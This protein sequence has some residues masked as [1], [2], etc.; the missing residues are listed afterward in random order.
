MRIFAISKRKLKSQKMDEFK[1]ITDY[2][3]KTIEQTNEI[4]IKTEK[5]FVTEGMGLLFNTHISFTGTTAADCITGGTTWRTAQN[6]AVS[7][8]EVDVLDAEAKLILYHALLKGIAVQAN[9]THPGNEL[10]LVSTGLTMAKVGEE[11]GE[12]DK[13]VIKSVV[14]VEGVAEHADI[15]FNTSKK[16]CYGTHVEVKNVATGAVVYKHSK[17]KH[18]VRIDGCL[19]AI[20][21]MVRVAYDG[22]DETRVWSEWFP[23]LGQ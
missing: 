12:M 7:G 1:L 2:S 3:K 21:Y 5:N 6:R 11:V 15:N 17:H 10:T 8:N 14:A 9:T 23:F 20:D 18:I 13:P 19:H 4:R 16:T 22:T